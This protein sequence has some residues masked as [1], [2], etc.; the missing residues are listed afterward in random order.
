MVGVIAGLTIQRFSTY[1]LS[2]VIGA[3]FSFAIPYIT[4]IAADKLGVSGVLAVVVNGLML[5]RLVFKHHDSHRH[6][7]AK[8]VWAD[9]YTILLNC[10][11]FILIGLQLGVIINL[12]TIEQIICI[13]PTLLS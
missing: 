1:L 4:Y 3:V 12:M 6:L 5:W 7:L 11:V 10:F 13:S 9:V 8:T 2:S